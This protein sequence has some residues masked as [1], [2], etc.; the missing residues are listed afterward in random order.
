M[1]GGEWKRQENNI[2]KV[3]KRKQKRKLNLSQSCLNVVNSVRNF[4]A[5]DGQD[6]PKDQDYRLTH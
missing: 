1:N 6:Y 4:G 5:E 2:K 3:N